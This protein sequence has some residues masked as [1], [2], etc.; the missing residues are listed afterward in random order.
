MIED[1]IY[2]DSCLHSI[3]DRVLIDIVG[4]G[5]IKHMKEGVITDTTFTQATSR[6]HKKTYIIDDNVDSFAFNHEIWLNKT[7]LKRLIN[8]MMGI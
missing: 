8:E 1:K 7:Q 3:G 4:H 2:I 6:I 5:D